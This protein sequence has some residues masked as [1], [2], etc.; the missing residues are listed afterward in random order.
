MVIFLVFKG[1]IFYENSLLGAALKITVFVRVEK[2]KQFD[3]TFLCAPGG[4]DFFYI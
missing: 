3:G 2:Q 1:V 4:R